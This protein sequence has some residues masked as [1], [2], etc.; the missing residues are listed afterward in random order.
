VLDQ[1]SDRILSID[2]ARVHVGAL[3]EMA[4][5]MQK[6]YFDTLIADVQQVYDVSIPNDRLVL[7][8][9]GTV[10]ELELSTMKARLR[11]GA[12]AKAARGKLKVL[13]PSRWLLSC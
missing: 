11:T 13:L 5:L 9:K 12:E 7:Q 1:P 8:I 6:G 10:A 2:H 4:A 3:L